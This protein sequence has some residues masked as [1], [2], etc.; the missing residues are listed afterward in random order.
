MVIISMEELANHTR[1]YS[2]SKVLF[3]IAQKF[4]NAS[5]RLFI[6]QIAIV[7]KQPRLRL[8]RPAVLLAKIRLCLEVFDFPR[9]SGKHGNTKRPE[10]ENATNSI[11]IATS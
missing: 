10:A 4:G 2:L 11:G 3:V 6:C 7:A 1:S 8:P 5:K 9:T